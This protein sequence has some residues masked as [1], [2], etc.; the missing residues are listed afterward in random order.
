MKTPKAKARAHFESEIVKM[1]AII[2]NNAKVEIKSDSDGEGDRENEEESENGQVAS[3]GDEWN[4][5]NFESTL[6]RL[7][8]SESHED[9]SSST[10]KKPK[11]SQVEK[12]G[13]K[14]KGKEVGKDPTP[15]VVKKEF[16]TRK[17]KKTLKSETKITAN[18]NSSVLYVENMEIDNEPTL[19]TKTMIKDD[20]KDFEEV[21]SKD[22]VKRKEE[23]Q[24]KS[25]RGN[26][27]KKKKRRK[28]KKESRDRTAESG[29]DFE[30]CKSN[31]N[32]SDETG[33]MNIENE[34]VVHSEQDED[35]IVGT[36]GDDIARLDETDGEEGRNSQKNNKGKKEKGKTKKRMKK[37]K[38][39]RES[40]DGESEKRKK[41]KSKKEKK[42]RKK[43]NKS[44]DRSEGGEKSNSNSNAL[45]CEMVVEDAFGAESGG[46]GSRE[47]REGET[48]PK[49]EV[50]GEEQTTESKKQTRGFDPRKRYVPKR[51]RKYLY[52][53]TV[54]PNISSFQGVI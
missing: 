43:K 49:F 20:E 7:L 37:S 19:L 15:N 22:G 39:L 27:K 3:E 21:I 1:E 24:R 4:D 33:E 31:P 28:S 34:I 26:S 10:K 40:D 23:K 36:I 47:G 12:K 32:E 41:S 6:N 2:A 38:Q 42:R 54:I 18:N 25:S 8:N 50:G 13:K 16:N 17:E 5:A 11:V 51:V 45:D 14:M 30:T 29:G 53:V 52:G 44:R 48:K 9:N 46:D 35:E